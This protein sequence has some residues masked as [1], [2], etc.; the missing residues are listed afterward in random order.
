MFS[1][2]TGLWVLFLVLFIQCAPCI[3]PS[4]YWTG[5]TKKAI[6]EKAMVVSA[7]PLASMV[8]N[9]ILHQGGNA[10]DAAVGVQLALAVVYPR[11]GNIGGGGFMVYRAASGETNSL[12]YREKA[13]ALASRDMYLDSLGKPGTGSILGH[14]ASGVPG[15]VD[16]LITAHA[17]YGKLSFEKIIAPAI[18]LAEE[19]FQITADEAA[20]LLDYRAVFISTNGKENAFIKENEWK[21]GDWLIQKDLAWTLKQIR[22]QGRAGFYEGPVAD[23]IVAEMH[24]G[25]GIIRH[26]DLK[27]YHS[28]WRKPV[29]VPYKEYKVISMAPPSS[30]GIAL[31]QLL[32]MV[33]PYPLK[34]WGFRDPRTIHLMVEAERRVYADRAQYLGDADFFPVPKDSLLDP[35]YL[36]YRMQDF[37]ELQASRSESIYAGNYKLALEHFETTHLSVVDQYGNAVAVTTTLNG[38]FGSKVI[39]DGAGFFMNN[40]MDDFSVKPGVPNMFGLI[41]GEANAIQPG[42]RMLSSMTPTILEKNGKLSMV[43]GTPGGST[44]ITSVFQVILNV[45]EWN[46]PMAEAAA[47]SRFH[48]QWLPDEIILEENAFD[49]GLKTQLETKGHKL[50]PIRSIGLVDAILV[51]PDG[52]LEGG[53]DP[54]G[55]DHAQGW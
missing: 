19:G 47:A 6:S 55:N 43:V 27:A 30:G 49:A 1:R 14:L 50:R 34:D 18:R 16:G 25:K 23:R 53:A 28:V 5:I 45:L 3:N 31:G 7:H 4:G 44:I 46:M 12:D 11:A 35:K 20:R 13:P 37:N 36:K 22:D 32:K 2:I 39:V 17:K 54:R 8:G 15:T 24:Q 33:E 10:V 21:E 40:E 29:I 41:G 38:N 9:R 42:K 26:E 52:S 48:H 51:R